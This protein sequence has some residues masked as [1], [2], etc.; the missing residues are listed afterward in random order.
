MS[1]NNWRQEY[2]QV[3]NII[4]NPVYK[5][6]AINTINE[7]LQVAEK[8]LNK[9]SSKLSVL[10]VGCGVGLYTNELAKH[11]QKVTAVEPFEKA[12]LQAKKIVPKKVKVY[13]CVVEDLKTADRFDLVLSLT[14]LEH[15]PD[16]ERSF[17]QI[18]KH[19]KIGGIIYLTAPN[20][21]WPI[22]CHYGLPF[23][24]W[25][26]LK[27]ANSYLKI[28]GKGQ[29]YEDSSHSKTYFGIK[30]LFNQLPCRYE[31]YLP[32]PNSL[33]LGCG[34][35]SSIYHL[36]KRIGITLIRRFP[37]MWMFS[38]GFILIIRKE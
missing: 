33:Y 13:N 29:S 22:E 10:D 14:S 30:H 6:I 31:L 9:K 4:K 5:K 23:L 27:L 32:N 25:L 16:A 3:K 11:V 21:L 17:R 2:F 12:Y 36:V 24:S 7:V 8:K 34:S 1:G 28:T 19:M 20:K 35:K 37:F 26:P 38:K 18:F 15:M